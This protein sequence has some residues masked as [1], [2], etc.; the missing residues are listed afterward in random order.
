MIF[1]RSHFSAL[2]L[3]SRMWDERYSEAEYVYGKKPNDFLA[4][5]YERIPQGKVLSLAEGE[6]RNAVFL[7]LQ[8]Y[9]VTAVDAS[10]VGLDK[11]QK[12][13]AENQVKIN[14]IQANLDDFEI[15]E[16]AWDGIISIFCPMTDSQRHV[17]HQKVIKGLKKDGVFLL[18]AYTPEQLQFATG[19][20]QSAELMTTKES[21]ERDFSGQLKI[22]KLHRIERRVVEGKYHTGMASVV[23][24][25]AVKA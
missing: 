14:T 8:N 4:E 22:L 1:E 25:I 19:G 12:L 20:G 21:L 2:G 3:E 13:A 9:D 11:A 18:E 17:L 5:N 7:A 15:E 23:Q 16:N 10:Q 24:L 6:G